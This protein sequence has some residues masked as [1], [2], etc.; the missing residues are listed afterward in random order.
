MSLHPSL[1]IDTAGV[2]N[3]T[4]YTRLERVKALMNKGEWTDE[5]SPTGLPKTK[6]FKV[7][8]RRKKVET[9]DDE[10]GKKKK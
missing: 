5:S 4:V 2:Q 6:I 10:K 7:K 8:A 1:K 3:R 9:K